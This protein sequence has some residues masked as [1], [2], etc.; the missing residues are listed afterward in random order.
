MSRRRSGKVLHWDMEA[1]RNRDRK[2]W[3]QVFEKYADQVY[4]YVYFRFQC[5]SDTAREITQEVFLQT[6]QSIGS[7]QRNP[8]G[9][10]RWILGI[11]KQVLT[12]RYR[13]SLRENTTQITGTA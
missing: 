12:R 13:A 8:Q 9:L 4:R 1:L 5:E 6:I 11:T 3:G 10:L 7:Y 2:T